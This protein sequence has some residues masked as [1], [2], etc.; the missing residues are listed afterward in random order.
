MDLKTETAWIIKFSVKGVLN[1]SITE[2][3]DEQTSLFTTEDFDEI[4]RE[5]RKWA[6]SNQKV[7]TFVQENYLAE[8]IQVFNEIP[9]DIASAEILN[10]VIESVLRETCSK[11][12]IDNYVFTKKVSY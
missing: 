6:T 4:Q 3:L 12:V 1:K 9:A 8:L 10:A 2:P 11:F 7:L 5:L